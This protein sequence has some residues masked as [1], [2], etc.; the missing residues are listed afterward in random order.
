MATV[1]F[2]SGFLDSGGGLELY[3][4]AMASGL[5]ARGWDVALAYHE[6]GDL[7]AAWRQVA[8]RMERIEGGASVDLALAPDGVAARQLD[9]VYL[10]SPSLMPEGL[11]A[12][13]RLGV[14]AVVHLHLPPDGL[15]DGWK[16]RLRGRRRAGH[17]DEAIIDPDSPVVKFLAVSQYTA[18]Q[19]AQYGVAPELLSVV[20]NGVDLTKFRPAEPGERDLLRTELGIAPDATAIGFMGRIDPNKGIEQLLVAFELLQADLPRSATSPNLVVTGQATRHLGGAGSDYTARLQAAYGTDVIWLGRRSDPERVFRALDLV[21][22]PSQ[23]PE[24]F[25]LV[26][27]EAMATGVAVIAGNRGG[28]PE[29]LGRPFASNVVEPKPRQLAAAM[30]R[31]IADPVQLAELGAHSRRHVAAEFSVEAALDETESHLKAA[32]GGDQ[33]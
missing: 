18:D 13:R 6:D 32:L 26:A 12:A 1:G 20:H 15:R 29:V 22:V 3:E 5:R 33:R 10:H 21:V 27:I 25:G 28:L 4:L 16:G 24:P 11:E 7:T 30:G 8:S 31:L 17:P 2:F 23:W 14:P 19:W 9:V